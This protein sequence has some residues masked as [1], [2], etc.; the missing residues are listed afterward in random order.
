[1]STCTSMNTDTYQVVLD[2]EFNRHSACR[3]VQNTGISSLAILANSSTVHVS[4]LRSPQPVDSRSASPAEGRRRGSRVGLVPP[5]PTESA[6]DRKGKR[7]KMVLPSFG[8]LAH[9]FTSPRRQ[10]KHHYTHSLQ[11]LWL[12]ALSA[13]HEPCPWLLSRTRPWGNTF[14][15]SRLL[16]QPPCR[17]MAAR[18]S[19]GLD[20]SKSARRRAPR[21]ARGSRSRLASLEK[22]VLGGP[23]GCANRARARAR[24]NLSQRIEC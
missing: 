11:V 13:H 19:G 17:Q 14:G 12:G 20:P 10:Y 9:F 2:H 5:M 6:W 21:P 18:G 7:Y 1:M 16:L 8:Q 22:H 24:R 3:N 15:T 4:R 23:G